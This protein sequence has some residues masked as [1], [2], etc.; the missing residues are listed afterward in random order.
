MDALSCDNMDDFEIPAFLRKQV[1]DSDSSPNALRAS[2]RKRTKATRASPLALLQTFEA[3]AQ[4]LLA[5][6][7]FVRKLQTLNLPDEL[8]SLID[9]LTVILGAEAKAWALVLQWLAERLRIRSL[10]HDKASVCYAMPSRTK[11]LS[12]QELK[13]TWAAGIEAFHEPGTS[14]RRRF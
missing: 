3:S 7:Q 6:H 1:D 13:L 4:K 9:N 8:V 5:P 14:N 12:L 11:P 2:P 10:C